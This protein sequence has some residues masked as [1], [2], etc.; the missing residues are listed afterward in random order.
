MELFKFLSETVA[1]YSMIKSIVKGTAALENQELSAGYQLYTELSDAGGEEEVL[2]T[3][4][5]R[6]FLDRDLSRKAFT[7]KDA[8]RLQLDFYE[9]FKND[10]YLY[11]RLTP[12]ISNFFNLTPIG[13]Y[14]RN[15]SRLEGFKFGCE[16]LTLW[17]LFNNKFQV[18]GSL[19]PCH[20]DFRFYASMPVVS[21]IFKMCRT[22]FEVLAL[23]NRVIE[24]HYLVKVKSIDHHAAAVFEWYLPTDETE[25]KRLLKRASRVD[26]GVGEY[27]SL[28]DII[29]KFGK[30]VTP[31]QQYP[32]YTTDIL[33]SLSELTT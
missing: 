20:V 5:A 2:S 8:I 31:H 11:Y 24:D 14:S 26:I 12:F 1:D 28:K 19:S 10:A 22:P 16:D 9:Q 4:E 33:N 6:S 25:R 3:T 27:F 18:L 21:S 32:A 15:L 13:V 17:G 7:L 29:V 30:T 23:A